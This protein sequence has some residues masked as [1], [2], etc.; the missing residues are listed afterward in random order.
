MTT[1]SRF[2]PSPTGQLH[3]GHAYAAWFAWDIARAATAGGTAGR[4]LVRLEDIDQGRCRPAFAAAILEDLAWLGVTWEEPVW[5]QT[6]HLE[7]HRGALAVLA[8]AGLVYPCFCTRR[9]IQAEIAAAAGAPHLAPAGPDG[10]LYPGTCRRLDPADRAARLAAG[11]A[12]AMRLDMVAA[13]ARAGA[14]RWYDRGRGWQDARSEA[15]GDVVLARKDAGTSYH[16]AVT[17]DDA[18]QGITVVTRAADLAP[19]SHVHRLLQALLDLPVPE[20]HHHALLTDAAGKRFAK[21]DRSVTLKDLRARGLG[22]DDVRTMTEAFVAAGLN[23]R[24]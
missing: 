8:D 4:F 2:A 10:P 19:A 24:P 22:P 6:E 14:L 21:R 11:V 13:T 18:A 16:L 3:L 9:D 15:F 23:R 5:R 17:V 1:V 20:W 7:A 12:H